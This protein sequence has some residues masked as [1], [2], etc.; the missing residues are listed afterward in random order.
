MLGVAASWLMAANQW[1]FWAT[2]ELRCPF[3]QLVARPVWFLAISHVD[4][5]GISRLY[6]SLCKSPGLSPSTVCSLRPSFHLLYWL[7]VLT[8]MHPLKSRKRCNTERKNMIMEEQK[9]AT[10]NPSTPQMYRLRPWGCHT[11][12]MSTFIGRGLT[13]AHKVEQAQR[14]WSKSSQSLD[15]EKQMRCTRIHGKCYDIYIYIIIFVIILQ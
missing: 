8:K 14:I 1:C 3:R 6:K 10:R 9:V 15:W 13:W 4:F 11:T 2:P 7:K 5:F 12:K